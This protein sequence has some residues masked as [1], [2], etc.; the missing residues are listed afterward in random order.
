MKADLYLIYNHLA[1]VLLLVAFGYLYNNNTFGQSEAATDSLISLSE[2]SGISD[3]LRLEIFEQIAKNQILNPR[4]RLKYTDKIYEIA[5]R[6]KDTLWL[7]KATLRYGH[8]YIKISQYDK[9]L[10]NYFKAI[11]CAKS[12][13]DKSKEAI[14]YGNIANIY[15]KTEDHSKSLLFYK[16][17][18]ILLHE[19]NDVKGLAGTY[20]NAAL[21]YKDIGRYDSSLLYFEKASKIYDSLDFKLGIAYN[22]GNTGLLYAKMDHEEKAQD[23]IERA[24]AILTELEAYYP[25]ADYDLSMADFYANKGNIKKAINYGL[26]SLQIASEYNLK[27]QLM[28]TNLKLSELYEMQNNFQQAYFHQEQYLVYRDSINNEE[29]IRKMADL[30]TEYEV[31]QKQLEV[32]MLENKREQQNI[33][34]IAMV[35]IIVLLGFLV[36]LYYRNYKRKQ[37]LNLIIT[38]RKEEV[39]AQRD[40]LEAMNETKEKFLSIVSHDLLGPVNSFKGLSAIMKTSIDAN[41]IRDLEYIHKLFDNSINNLST[42]LTNLL[43]WSVTQQGAI[44]YNPERIILANLVNELL[45]LFSNMGRTKELNLISTVHDDAIVWADENSVKTILRNLVSN[46]IKFTDA[47]GEIIVSAILKDG[48]IGISVADS[49]IG[50]TQEKIDN[51]LA[52]DNYNRSAGTKG[53]KGIGLGLQLVKEFTEMNKGRIEIQSEVRVGTT[54]TVFLPSDETL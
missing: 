5:S 34:F 20:N 12:L 23:H 4:L 18:I 49:G 52:Y 7:Y 37:T 31:A 32:D 35:V 29:T 48:M 36:F 14:V 46:A 17:G 22:I 51:L 41:N 1:K 3:S 42:L 8:N 26:H 28:D 15:K 13:R 30:Q 21:L 53:E 47:N 44:P 19:L 40:Q 25:I 43:D 27:E 6:K 50:M 11:Q 2:K 33:I 9:A 54:I 45:D 38:E 10:E 39:E 24:I 16:R